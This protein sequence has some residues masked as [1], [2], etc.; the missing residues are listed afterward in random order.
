MARNAEADHA[1]LTAVHAVA[2]R[3]AHAEAAAMAQQALADGLE[4][5]LLFN[6]AALD[7]GSAGP[8]V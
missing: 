1:T 3:G 5:P 4:H 2:T 6:L 7:L 8:R